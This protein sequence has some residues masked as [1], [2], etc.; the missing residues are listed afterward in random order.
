MMSIP[1]QISGSNKGMEDC[2]DYLR[3]GRCKYGASCKYNHPP[4]VQNGGGLKP[5]DPTEPLFPS[6][7]NEPI[8]Q[9]FLKHGTCKFGQACKFDHPA[10]NSRHF[11]TVGGQLV[12]FVN[13]GQANGDHPQATT[14][15]VLNPV[16][17]ETNGMVLQFLPQRVDEPDCIYFLKNGRC[18]YGATC[19]YHHPVTPQGNR[20]LV[21]NKPRRQLD[22]YNR[23]GQNVQYVAQMV[24]SYSSSQG[25]QSHMSYDNGPVSYVNIDGNNRNNA[26]AQS[27]QI[28]TG[29]DGV[30]SYCIPTGSVVGTEQCS[31]ASS[32][33]SSFEASQEHLS[34][35]WNRARRN[36][37]GSSL[38]GGP[39][40]EGRPHRAF[41]SHS[42][43][44]GNI[45]QRQARSTSYGSAGEMQQP[46]SSSLSRNMSGGPWNQRLPATG[47]QF[48]SRQ[49][50]NSRSTN[51]HQSQH[52]LVRRRDPRGGEGHDE[53]FTMMTSALLN[54]LD[55]PDEAAAE[56]FSDD[57]F[58]YHTTDQYDERSHTTFQYGEQDQLDYNL[59]DRMTLQDRNLSHDTL[60][61]EEGRNYVDQT[62]VKQVSLRGVYLPT[63]KLSPSSGTN[64]ETQTAETG[65]SWSPTWLGAVDG[66][67]DSAY[68]FSLMQSNI[69]S[70]GPQAS[71]S[72]HD[73]DIGLYLP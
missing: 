11:V 38:S 27:Y 59:F 20:R 22:P 53:G 21:E 41:L 16:G 40:N 47:S 8:C 1:P 65:Q 13:S 4:N 70:H 61:H 37:S 29:S 44:E 52:R 28:V 68:P 7:P 26:S 9:Y 18:K 43:S 34:E 49:E 12:Q 54:M 19:R 64:E 15:L 5:I 2:R 73:S 48:V 58:R 25:L 33:A 36:G 66:P 31:S 10:Q 71:T 35:Q 45:L 23:N 14:P 17:S 30:T 24:P 63:D 46:Q 50:S 57:E 51:S 72:S 39:A 6:R 55:T 42:V 62:S 56:G 32:I 69:P 67:D 60:L 3:T